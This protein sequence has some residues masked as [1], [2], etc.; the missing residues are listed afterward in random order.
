[1]ALWHIIFWDQLR[2]LRGLVRICSKDLAR[3][4]DRMVRKLCYLKAQY[5]LMTLPGITTLLLDIRYMKL[6]LRMAHGNSYIY[7]VSKSYNLFRGIFQV[8]GRV[9]GMWFTTCS[10]II[11]Y[12]R[13]DVY[14]I[15]FETLLTGS[16]KKIY[17]TLYLRTKLIFLLRE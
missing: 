8:N 2:Q 12:L 1:M 5:W 17:H 14:I 4:Y 7:Y 13:E 16:I 3:L 9:P 15:R 11:Q 10:K 6:F